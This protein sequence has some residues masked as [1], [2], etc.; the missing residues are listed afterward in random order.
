VL[1]QVFSRYLQ[2]KGI[3]EMPLERNISEANTEVR[4]WPSMRGDE[5]STGF[6]TQTGPLKGELL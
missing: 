2:K 6:T 5:A 4:N 1:E 3:L